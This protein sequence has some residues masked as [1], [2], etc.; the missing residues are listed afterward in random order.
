M[1]SFDK[2]FDAAMKQA[3]S[4]EEKLADFIGEFMREVAK[5][6]PKVDFPRVVAVSYVKA[7]A[8]TKLPLSKIAEIS[9]RQKARIEKAAGTTFRIER[10]SYGEYTQRVLEYAIK[11]TSS[12]DKETVGPLLARAKELVDASYSLKQDKA[13]SKVADMLARVEELAPV[14]KLHPHPMDWRARKGDSL[15]DYA[16]YIL[17]EQGAEQK[18]RNTM[19]LVEAAVTTKPSTEFAELAR[20]M[21]L[22]PIVKN[23][24]VLYS[25]GP[26]KV[27]GDEARRISLY[28]PYNQKVV[29]GARLLQGTYNGTSWVFSSMHL[30]EVKKLCDLYTTPVNVPPPQ[31]FKMEK[32]MPDQLQ[33]LHHL[34]SSGKPLSYYKGGYWSLAGQPKLWDHHRAST[35]WYV[36]K[37]TVDA[38]EAKGWLKQLAQGTNYDIRQ[39]P[40]LA[41]RA[42]TDDAHKVYNK[43]K[44]QGA[45]R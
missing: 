38:M 22:A 25:N 28:G 44:G 26:C 11:G 5:A 20:K 9:E 36:G 7:L 39:F 40:A 30:A 16:K 35:S 19:K 2:S 12:S 17:S 45:D 8:G 14:L 42:A 29:D 3:G 27:I 1:S 43:W 13:K 18:K 41:D 34:I 4:N 21:A 6:T 32:P 10:N 37:K 31:P 24:E 15:Y 33:V 23:G